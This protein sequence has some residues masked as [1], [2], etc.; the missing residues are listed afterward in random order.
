[1]RIGTLCCQ[2]LQ[3]IQFPGNLGFGNT[4]KELPDSGLGTGAH[5]F[6]RAERH[7]VAFVDQKH[8]VSDQKCARQF[9]RNHNDGHVERTLEFQNQFVN[10]CCDDG[11]QSS[12]GLVEK[13]DLR[14][15][16]QRAGYCG[17]FLH[18]TT[19]LRGRVIFESF[20]PDLLQFEPKD[21]FNSGVFQS[22]M[23]SKR[24]SHVFTHGHRT[25]Q[26]SALEGHA[27]FP[28]DLVHF[29]GGGFREI[30]AFDPY[31]TG[32]GFFEPH[33]R[34][35]KCAFPR[36]R[37]AKDHQGF[38]A[39][40]VEADAVQ[41][42]SL[43]VT[44][45]QVPQRKHGF[46]RGSRKYSSCS[47]QLPAKKNRTVKN[48]STTTTRKMDLTTACVVDRPTCSAPAPV[49]SPSRQPTA[50]MVMPNITLFTNPVVMSR[51]NRESIEVWM[52]R[53]RV[54]SAW[55][56][57]NS[58]PP[59]MP[60]ALAQMVKQGNITIMARNFGATRNR[61]GLMAIVS[62]ASIS[63]LTFIVPISAA[64][65]EPE[66]P[67]TMMAVIKGPSSR[68]METATIVATALIAPNLRSS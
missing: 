15:H 42:L 22:S 14:V 46:D 59:R 5:L 30:P 11:I 48:K 41:N 62:S 38:A 50:V 29:C 4:I 63:S 58:E 39:H 2:H 8:V 67:I 36:P 51:R 18:A 33:Q 68:D 13:Q 66:R 49:D 27:D 1:M 43:S 55:A 6:G 40:D 16:R 61:I 47:H 57:P 65:A 31:L 34:A 53:T 24:Q 20:E 12:R 28:S 60:M 26:S 21:D 37:T 52:Y 7:D 32:A 25:E 3:V 17:A 35:K 19:K 44:D 23:F 64:N 9:V 54:K 45:A 10:A 56:T